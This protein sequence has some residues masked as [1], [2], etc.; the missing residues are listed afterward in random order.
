MACYGKNFL[1]QA[2]GMETMVR[3]FRYA[4]N[5][6]QG[7]DPCVCFRNQRGG[8]KALIGDLAGPCQS[9]MYPSEDAKRTLAHATSNN[10]NPY[11]VSEPT[12]IRTRIHSV[13][14]AERSNSAIVSF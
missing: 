8:K 11:P 9:H 6:C 13:T 2:T 3:N 5:Q 4:G 12:R 10:K 14:T 7:P 1:H